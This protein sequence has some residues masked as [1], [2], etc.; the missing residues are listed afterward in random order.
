MASEPL[1]F[2]AAEKKHNMPPFPTVPNYDAKVWK[3]IPK[4][5]ALK[6]HWMWNVGAEPV[7]EDGTIF[8]RVDSY[9][10]WGETR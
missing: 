6:D 5:S 9:R 10:G 3:Y 7:L 4:G 2:T 8:D 1:A